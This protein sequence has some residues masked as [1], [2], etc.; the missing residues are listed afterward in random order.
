MAKNPDDVFSDEL[1]E[2]INNHGLYVS[3]EYIEEYRKEYTE[4]QETTQLLLDTRAAQRNYLELMKEL[5]TKDST[6]ATEMISEELNELGFNS[7]KDIKR[8]VLQKR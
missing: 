6:L 4:H 1:Y 3:R 7:R 5:Q 8:L 2:I